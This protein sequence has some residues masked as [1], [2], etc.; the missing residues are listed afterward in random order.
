LFYLYS[1]GDLLAIC[2]NSRAYATVLRLLS[3]VWRHVTL[4]GQTRDPNTLSVQYL[5]NSWR[6]CLA[7]IANYKILCCKAVRLTILCVCLGFLCK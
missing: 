3:L 5:H 6:C 7:T 2:I 4:K 1:Y